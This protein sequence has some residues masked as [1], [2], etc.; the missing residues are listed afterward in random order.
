MKISYE[1]L[2][3]II[4]EEVNKFKMLNEQTL[5]LTAFNK[6]MERIRGIVTK[7]STQDVVDRIA[8]A[9]KGIK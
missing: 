3:Q 9:L 1:R 8:A 4:E 5:N 7:E 2:N 6:E